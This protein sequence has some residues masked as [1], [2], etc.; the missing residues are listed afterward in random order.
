MIGL[1]LIQSQIVWVKLAMENPIKP[2]NNPVNFPITTP[3][4]KEKQ[5][6]HVLQDL[7]Q[8]LQ[9]VPLQL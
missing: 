6:L 7:S 4:L 8:D 9:G 2:I 5:S 3:P 1:L